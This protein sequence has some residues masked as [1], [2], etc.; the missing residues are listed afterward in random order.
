LHRNYQNYR[1]KPTSDDI[2]KYSDQIKKS[3]NGSRRI[4]EYYKFLDR[5]FAPHKNRQ[6]YTEFH[7]AL[8]KLGFCGL[9]TT[10]YDMVLEFCRWSSKRRQR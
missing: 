6:N 5:I 2:L 1:K 10:N 3:A 9:V 7:C 4:E 8:I